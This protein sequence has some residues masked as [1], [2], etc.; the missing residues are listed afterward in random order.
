MEVIATFVYRMGIEQGQ[1]GYTTAVNL[2]VSLI[3]FFLVFTT[4][5]IVRKLSPE[6]SLW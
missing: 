6:N 3:S 4:N 5:M 2:L 1:F